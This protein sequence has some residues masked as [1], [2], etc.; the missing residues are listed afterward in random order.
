MGT[1]QGKTGADPHHPKLEA[2]TVIDNYPIKINN[3]QIVNLFENIYYSKKTLTWKDIVNEKQIT[4]R[5]CVDQKIPIAK[6]HKM[7]PDLE[8]WIRHG[9]V[10]LKDCKDMTL[11]TPNPFYHFNC[12]IGDLVIQRE[13]LT[14]TV[15]LN[16][17]VKFN[18]LWDRYGLTPDI[19]AL[20]KYSPEDWVR[21][22]ITEDHLDY[23]NE[24][25]WQA[26]FQRLKKDEVIHAI[27]YNKHH[28]HSVSA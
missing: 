21:L 11:W 6:L 1:N 13:H 27:Q 23:F 26:V 19:M 22:G 16:G 25:Q 4:F 15:L 14:P 2:G 7:Q 12:C 9:K 28:N 5:K 8:E 17:G 24:K 20:I 3:T 18:I 10:E